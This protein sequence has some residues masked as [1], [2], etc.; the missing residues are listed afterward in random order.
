M[1]Q[2]PVHPLAIAAKVDRREVPEQDEAPYVRAAPEHQDELPREF[3]VL[4]VAQGQIEG[5]VRLAIAEATLVAHLNAVQVR[6][7]ARGLRRH[8]PPLQK[9]VGMGRV[10]K[11]E[12]KRD[13]HRLPHLGIPAELDQVPVEE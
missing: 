12:H 4:D 5:P 13:D 8:T 11:A 7:D 9:R 6:C 2:S 10:G 3:V 1:L